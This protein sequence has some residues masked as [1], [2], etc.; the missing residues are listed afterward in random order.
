MSKETYHDYVIKAGVFIGDFEGMYQR[1]DQPWMQDQQPNPYA[2]QAGIT[3]IRK[4]GIRSLL[5]CGSGLGYYTEQIYQHTGI[6]PEGIELSE[7]AVAKAKQQFPH[8]NFRVDTVLNFSDYRHVDAVL[9]AE[10]TWYILPDLPRLFALMQ[11][12]FAGKYFIHNLVFYKGSQRYG[13]EYF[14]NL[15]EFINYVPFTLVGSC[16]ATTEQDSTIETS[17][18]FRID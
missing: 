15:Q 9:F 17:T 14:T 10:I 6:I 8:L 1:F 12:H 5:E 7:T 2:R 11:E 18:I 3:H 4:F 16:E 13:T